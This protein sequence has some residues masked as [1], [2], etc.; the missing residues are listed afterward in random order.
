[1]RRGIRKATIA[2]TLQQ[3]WSQK[4]G[5]AAGADGAEQGYAFALHDAAADYLPSS[6]GDSDVK[7]RSQFN[8]DSASGAA[9]EQLQPSYVVFERGSKLSKTLET[10]RLYRLQ[11]AD[12]Q[13][14]YLL[15]R[16]DEEKFVDSVKGSATLS[17]DQKLADAAFDLQQGGTREPRSGS[18]NLASGGG[19]RPLEH[20]GEEPDSTAT[21][22]G[23]RSVR[24]QARLLEVVLVPQTSEMEY[25][26]ENLE[27]TLTARKQMTKRDLWHY[28]RELLDLAGKSQAPVFYQG[29]VPPASEYLVEGAVAT[30]VSLAAVGSS[31]EQA[32]PSTGSTPA[33]G[34]GGP[35]T[36]SRGVANIS[37]AAA[38]P[39]N[40]PKV[41]TSGGKTGG[42]TP[43][44]SSATDSGKRAPKLQSGLVVKKTGI[45]FRSTAAEIFMFIEISQEIFDFSQAGEAL[46]YQMLRFMS[47]CIELQKK[48]SCDH[49]LVILLFGRSRH[50]IGC[51]KPG[52]HG[53]MTPSRGGPGQDAS[54]T[55]V[56]LSTPVIAA[57]EDSTSS[58]APLHPIKTCKNY[59]SRA[60]QRDDQHSIL[61]SPSEQS[62]ALTA[63]NVSHL[64]SVK[65]NKSTTTVGFEMT[66]EEQ[67]KERTA[68]TSS[69][70]R[71]SMNAD[72]PRRTETLV[73]QKSFP[74]VAASQTVQAQQEDSKDSTPRGLGAARQGEDS[75]E[76]GT[77]KVPLAGA[78]GVFS[79][80]ERGAEKRGTI[81]HGNLLMGNGNARAKHGVVGTDNLISSP[82]SGSA[83]FD[84]QQPA[85]TPKVGSGTITAPE[86]EAVTDWFEV[87]W[88]GALSSLP[89]TSEFVQALSERISSFD[90]RTQSNRF[91]GDVDQV[92]VAPVTSTRVS[93]R[94]SVELGGSCASPRPRQAYQFHN[95]DA[96][97]SKHRGSPFVLGRS[98]VGGP[99]VA[100]GAT[101]TTGA[102]MSASSDVIGTKLE[103]G[104]ED[105]QRSETI[106][107]E[108]PIG[109]SPEVMNRVDT[110]GTS[111]S[112]S[113]TALDVPALRK[114]GIVNLVPAST[115]SEVHAPVLNKPPPPSSGMSGPTFSLDGYKGNRASGVDSGAESVFSGHHIAAGCTP[116]RGNSMRGQIVQQDPST[117]NVISSSQVDAATMAIKTGG[118]HNKQSSMLPNLDHQHSAERL[119]ISSSVLSQRMMSASCSDSFDASGGRCAED[120][121]A[122]ARVDTISDVQEPSLPGSCRQLPFLEALNVALDAFEHH[123]LDRNL[124]INGQAI[125][126]LSANHGVVYTHK[127]LFLLTQRRFSRMGVRCFLV[128]FRDRPLHRVPLVLVPRPGGLLHS[129]HAVKRDAFL[130]GAKRTSSSTSCAGIGKR[131]GR[132]NYKT[133]QTQEHHSEHQHP[134]FY[135]SSSNMAVTLQEEQYLHTSNMLNELGGGV[136]WRNAKNSA[137]A[138]IQ[139]GNETYSSASG[140]VTD[141]TSTMRGNMGSGTN[142]EVPQHQTGVSASIGGAGVQFVFLDEQGSDSK[143]DARHNEEGQQGRPTSQEERTTAAGPPAAGG[144]KKQGAEATTA[145]TGVSSTSTGTTAAPVARGTVQPPP[146]QEQKHLLDAVASPSTSSPRG[147]SLHRVLEEGPFSGSNTDSRA[148]SR[149]IREQEA[150]L[151][152]PWHVDGSPADSTP[153]SSCESVNA[154]NPTMTQ[155]SLGEPSLVSSG[156]ELLLDHET[157]PAPSQQLQTEVDLWGVAYGKTSSLDF[158]RQKLKAQQAHSKVVR[159][160]GKPAAEVREFFPGNHTSSRRDQ[161]AGVA[162]GGREH[163]QQDNLIVG[164]ARGSRER[165][166][167]SSA[168]RPFKYSAG[169]GVLGGGQLSGASPVW[170]H[171]YS[172]QS[173][174]GSQ[175]GGAPFLLS[176]GPRVDQEQ[177]V[178]QNALTPEASHPDLQHF[179]AASSS[180]ALLAGTGGSHQFLHRVDSSGQPLSHRMSYNKYPGSPDQHNFLMKSASRM[181]SSSLIGN[182]GSVSQLRMLGSMLAA[183]PSGSVPSLIPSPASKILMRQVSQSGYHNM[184]LQ[185]QAASR[186]EPLNMSGLA[187]GRAL[188]GC[189]RDIRASNI[190]VRGDYNHFCKMGAIGSASFQNL[191]SEAVMQHHSFDHAAAQRPPL[192]QAGHSNTDGVRT[193]SAQQSLL[194][195]TLNG[196][197]PGVHASS[198][199]LSASSTMQRRRHGGHAVPVVNYTQLQHSRGRKVTTRRDGILYLPLIANKVEGRYNRISSSTWVEPS[200]GSNTRKPFQKSRGGLLLHSSY[201]HITFWGNEQLNIQRLHFYDNA[202]RICVQKRTAGISARRALKM[203][204]LSAAASGA[205]TYVPTGEQYQPRAGGWQR[206]PLK[207]LFPEDGGS[208]GSDDG[209]TTPS[210]GGASCKSSKD[211]KTKTGNTAA[212]GV[213]VVVQASSQ[214][215]PLQLSRQRNIGPVPVAASS[216]LEARGS[217]TG[218]EEVRREGTSPARTINLAAPVSSSSSFPCVSVSS[219]DRTSMMSV[220]REKQVLPAPGAS[221]TSANGGGELHSHSHGQFYNIYGADQQNPDCTA[222]IT[223]QQQERV[224][225][226]GPSGSPTSLS[227]EATLAASTIKKQMRSG[228]SYGAGH[229]HLQQGSFATLA[230]DDFHLQVQQEHLVPHGG[231]VSPGGDVSTSP[232]FT[233]VASEPGF[234]RLRYQEMFDE[235]APNF[236]AVVYYPEVSFFDDSALR[237]NISSLYGLDSLLEQC[238]QFELSRQ[239]RIE[240]AAAEAV[241]RQVDFDRT[242]MKTT[243]P[244]EGA[245]DVGTS[246]AENDETEISQSP[247]TSTITKRSDGKRPQQRDEG[248]EEKLALFQVVGIDDAGNDTSALDSDPGEQSKTV[249]P[250]LRTEGHTNTMEE[251]K[252][253]LLPEGLLSNHDTERISADRGASRLRTSD[254][255]DTDRMLPDAGGRQNNKAWMKHLQ[256]CSAAAGLAN[257][258]GSAALLLP[259]PAEAFFASYRCQSYLQERQNLGRFPRD[260]LPGSS[261]K[262]GVYDM[263]ASGTRVRAVVELEAVR[264]PP[265]RQELVKYYN[266]V[267]QPRGRIE[268]RRSRRRLR[269]RR[270]RIKAG[271]GHAK[272]LCVGGDISE[273]QGLGDDAKERNSSSTSTSGTTSG[274]SEVSEEDCSTGSSG[275]DPQLQHLGAKGQ[276]HQQDQCSAGST[277]TST[278]P[279]FVRV[280]GRLRRP[281][282]VP[283]WTAQL[284]DHVAAGRH[285]HAEEHSEDS[286]T[287]VFSTPRPPAVVQTSPRPLLGDVTP[288]TIG[289]SS[290]SKTSTGRLMRLG[291]TP[292]SSASSRLGGSGQ[293]FFVSPARNNMVTWPRMVRAKEPLRLETMFEVATP[294]HGGSDSEA[295]LT[296][297]TTAP[298]GTNQDEN[299]S[300][301]TSI[302]SQSAEGRSSRPLGKAG[303]GIASSAPPINP[304]DVLPATGRELLEQAA[305]R[306][307][308]VASASSSGVEVK[309]S[310]STVNNKPTGLRRV[311]TSH[312]SSP[313]MGLPVSSSNPRVLKA[314]TLEPTSARRVQLAG[315]VGSA[316]DYQQQPLPNQAGQ[317]TA[318]QKRRS[319]SRPNPFSRRH[320]RP[321][322]IGREYNQQGASFASHADVSRGRRVLAPV[323]ESPMRSDE[324]G[325]GDE[326]TPIHMISAGAGSTTTRS[327]TT[328]SNSRDLA[329]QR[330]GGEAAESSTPSLSPEKRMAHER[331]TSRH[332]RPSGKKLM[333]QKAKRLLGKSLLEGKH[334]QSSNALLILSQRRRLNGAAFSNYG[335]S[336][337]GYKN[338]RT[339]QSS[340]LG[341]A[342]NSLA[343][344]DEDRAG[345]LVVGPGGATIEDLDV[346][347]REE[348]ERWVAARFELSEENPSYFKKAQLLGLTALW[349]VL[350]SP[351]LLP[352]FVERQRSDMGRKSD[353]WSCISTREGSANQ[354][355]RDL[356]GTRLVCGMQVFREKSDREISISASADMRAAVVGGGSKVDVSGVRAVVC[357]FDNNW[358]LCHSIAD[359]ITVT[360]HDK[361]FAAGGAAAAAGGGGAGGSS[362]SGTD[363]N[364]TTLQQSSLLAGGAS[365]SP[366]MMRPQLHHGVGSTRLGPAP[367]PAGTQRSLSQQ[368]LGSTATVNLASMT[369]TGM[370]QEVDTVATSNTAM[371]SSG[372]GDSAFLSGPRDATG[373][374]SSFVVGGSE[375]SP[376]MLVASGS[377]QASAAQYGGSGP[378]SARSSSRLRATSPPMENLSR[379]VVPR[380]QARTMGIAGQQVRQGGNT[381]GGV[382]DYRSSPLLA[383]ATNSS[384]SVGPKN[385]GDTLSPTL[386]GVVPLPRGPQSVARASSGPSIPGCSRDYSM[387]KRAILHENGALV[388]GTSPPAG[389]HHHHGISTEEH[390]LSLSMGDGNGSTPLAGAPGAR[391]GIS[392][393]PAS[394]MGRYQAAQRGIANKRPLQFLPTSSPSNGASR[395]VDVGAML[396]KNDTSS[397]AAP[398]ASRSKSSRENLVQQTRLAEFGNRRQRDQDGSTV[399]EE[400]KIALAVA[401][402]A[403]VNDTRPRKNISLPV[404]P[405]GSRALGSSE[406]ETTKRQATEC[407][408]AT[409]LATLPTSRQS[410]LVDLPAAGAQ[411]TSPPNLQGGRSEGEGFIGGSSAGQPSAQ[412]VFKQDEQVCLV[413]GNALEFRKP[414]ETSPAGSLDAVSASSPS[415]GTISP[416]SITGTSAGKRSLQSDVVRAQRAFFSEGAFP[417]APALRVPATS[418][419]T[420]ATAFASTSGI[421]PKMLNTRGKR[422]AIAP[423]QELFIS[424]QHVEVD[425]SARGGSRHPRAEGSALPDD[426]E[427]RAAAQSRPL[428][429]IELVE[430]TPGA[431]QA[432]QAFASPS[433]MLLE[434]NEGPIGNIDQFILS[435]PPGGGVGTVRGSVLLPGEGSLHPKGG[436]GAGNLNAQTSRAAI[437]DIVWPY[438]YILRR[439]ILRFAKRA[440][441]FAE[442]EQAAL[443]QPVR[444]PRQAVAPSSQL[445]AGPDEGMDAANK[446]RN[447]YTNNRRSNFS[448]SELEQDLQ[449]DH[450]GAAGSSSTV[451]GRAGGDGD[452]RGG[453]QGA[454]EDDEDVGGPMDALTASPGFQRLLSSSAKASD[455]FSAA[456]MSCSSFSSSSN[457]TGE[458]DDHVSSGGDGAGAG[459]NQGEP[460][461]SAAASGACSTAFALPVWSPECRG[462]AK[463]FPQLQQSGRQNALV[464]RTASVQVGGGMQR[465]VGSVGLQVVGGEEMFD[466][467]AFCSPT[468]AARRK[469]NQSGAVGVM[470]NYQR[471]LKRG[472][473]SPTSHAI[474]IGGVISSNVVES[475]GPY[476]PLSSIAEEYEQYKVRCARSCAN[477]S[478]NGWVLQKRLFCQAD[479]LP[480]NVIDQIVSE[481]HPLPAATPYPL[482]DPNEKTPSAYHTAWWRLRNVLRSIVFVLLPVDERRVEQRQV[483]ENLRIGEDPFL[484]DCDGNVSAPS[485]GGGG[486]GGGGENGSNSKSGARASPVVGADSNVKTRAP[487]KKAQLGSSSA[488]ENKPV[489]FSPPS[490]NKQHKGQIEDTR[491]VIGS[492]SDPWA[493]SRDPSNVFLSEG[494]EP[495]PN[496]PIAGDADETPHMVL[497]NQQ[498]DAVDH[499]LGGTSSA[500]VDPSNKR[501]MKT[502]LLPGVQP[503][504]PSTWSSAGA[505]SSLVATGF[506][507]VGVAPSSLS[508]KDPSDGS[509]GKLEDHKSSTSDEVVEKGATGTVSPIVVPRKLSSPA[510]RPLAPDLRPL[511]DYKPRQDHTTSINDAPHDQHQTGTMGQTRKGP[512]RSRRERYVEHFRKLK[513]GLEAYLFY[514]A[515][516]GEGEQGAD[517]NRKKNVL[518][519]EIRTGAVS[520]ASCGSS[521]FQREDNFRRAPPTR[522]TAKVPVRWIEKRP[523]PWSS[524]EWLQLHHDNFY[525]PLDVFHISVEWILCSNAT[526]WKFVQ[527]LALLAVQN[528][529]RLQPIPHGE[530]LPQLSQR[531][532]MNSNDTELIYKRSPFSSRIGIR[533]PIG[534]RFNHLV[535]ALL[536]P[537]LNLV[538]VYH[539]EERTSKIIYNSSTTSTRAA[540]G[541]PAGLG[542]VGGGDGGEKDRSIEQ[543]ILSTEDEQT[544]MLEGNTKT[545]ST[546]HHQ[547]NYRSG[548]AA[549]A[550][551]AASSQLG[552][553]RVNDMLSRLIGL[554]YSNPDMPGWI[555]MQRESG[556]YFITVTRTQIFWTESKF[557]GR[558]ATKKLSDGMMSSYESRMDQHFD[559]FK[560]ALH[561]IWCESRQVIMRGWDEDEHF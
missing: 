232:E 380:G 459:Q 265:K 243:T 487:G 20:L 123:T 462:S 398:S 72:S 516:D 496:L 353:N 121:F 358:E 519:I 326:M 60:E 515:P 349:S 155:H 24:A 542:E 225:R 454:F 83:T 163:Q 109:Y 209:A 354:L 350:K 311:L 177:W 96:R 503:A 287:S 313:G 441:A 357:N 104:G 164:S 281:L 307:S 88:S 371:P 547:N 442:S 446:S 308:W 251:S 52:A 551:G 460:T 451:T 61:S 317:T 489:L 541:A 200:A 92:E 32:P 377:P 127:Q 296:N 271:N 343:D 142:P 105:L 256:S 493:S 540:G 226:E 167:S 191:L 273:E 54:G 491:Y 30:S 529:F 347:A 246:D 510:P 348:S 444:G 56:V 27:V 23:L 212:P 229:L 456:S 252:Q 51:K 156:G 205:S 391:I 319:R 190:V 511:P 166:Q 411:Q 9:G 128:C 502:T 125:F 16:I 365:W 386:T 345:Q 41:V 440:S 50:P 429:P 559:D 427:P 315:A 14:N 333:G 25:E 303:I 69:V 535:E 499:Q 12:A 66:L 227:H 38:P 524:N 75:A 363:D 546:L 395:S 467:A 236:F 270:S 165:F 372:N 37:S 172:N 257:N 162:R 280:A 537:P 294:K 261:K 420:S 316:A 379:Q 199:K 495:G 374:A 259:S 17:I 378:S 447:N 130:S 111:S 387:S 509:S 338:P 417:F 438:Q 116:T 332:G 106:P 119:S 107:P 439:N 304:A 143:E 305:G 211:T 385:A 174:W 250:N 255:A 431:H 405:E 300:P 8:K 45:S 346:E 148:A 291:A 182:C 318:E 4:R 362:P 397:S 285:L 134:D 1:M 247:S 538:L 418:S 55:P 449:Q 73:S 129:Y 498:E 132:G 171:F 117:T 469:T 29:F 175:Q 483:R 352:I 421:E 112:E 99:S 309:T 552:G 76:P 176:R 494:V 53:L 328:K 245:G 126:V 366:S 274:S 269:L 13:Y 283:R 233:V 544:N 561:R 49:E 355:F 110:T 40:M 539:H 327:A 120:L 367:A 450:G 426:G 289:V 284:E 180:P 376:I 74:P 457:S 218:A 331:S 217:R 7:E 416:T 324:G 401:A 344:E 443:A 445:A 159:P 530:L 102:V 485:G 370:I 330:G 479:P 64:Q 157:A 373:Q 48:A 536:S 406:D 531:A 473:I 21:T 458:Q 555:F 67:H 189:D 361:V 87:A 351:P 213:F 187:S 219:P 452:D 290:T 389:E 323:S 415:E 402:P 288:L 223:S 543:E 160:G 10:G 39:T 556:L 115:T 368:A 522:R 312:V 77:W 455:P 131:G 321:N 403:A 419:S 240:K 113:T 424:G 302:T 179:Y 204:I 501:N 260:L 19:S 153:T 359:Q 18:G 241:R 173:S 396:S 392:R 432:Q 478:R 310:V 461:R 222:A 497:N 423:D 528:R 5:G 258:F 122:E 95:T 47:E 340:P 82:A 471:D 356:V 369:A 97:L 35:T 393:S 231:V 235:L 468:A 147:S 272:N 334:P 42:L 518:D 292:A 384:P 466:A 161:A 135:G 6:V 476:S 203:N 78:R 249:I 275:S 436:G 306:A 103:S 193:G 228:T 407:S 59:N 533:I 558:K 500:A 215:S 57:H 144:K 242:Q 238:T 197:T 58:S 470:F 84:E 505:P 80:R 512:K 139:T 492:D 138:I 101:T 181:S 394:M 335:S 170:Q 282:F 188:L 254:V 253:L 3:R 548:G 388:D 560:R 325:G 145:T 342:G 298:G 425:A 463:L 158:A 216:S 486:L 62:R 448:T 11:F 93:K 268:R 428:S 202:L 336:S 114:S 472:V 220:P 433:T 208:G 408:C 435:G 520:S 207:G 65:V 100:P 267:Q 390:P 534:V 488:K 532:V 413:R 480:W 44:S 137:P 553:D 151:S 322:I 517:K 404:T 465:T 545:W 360:Q 329:R 279:A 481:A 63:E 554:D 28:Q 183:N 140:T 475:P 169:G 146:G 383:H 46:Y 341:R 68:S 453:L 320:S 133:S 79:G 178:I 31:Q 278:S 2:D 136:S 337:G 71:D 525:D 297:T 299:M 214:S 15:V 26:L 210:G 364:A 150:Y 521:S 43:S 293:P 399:D 477:F 375:R 186:G 98:L 514:N 414:L 36:G 266:N 118:H 490:R 237:Q 124:L 276:P 221:L 263:A 430:G 464:G 168:H 339:L 192:E 506:G 108:L 400:G 201:S 557:L 484:V 230:G 409:S 94:G 508:P 504:G 549:R 89:S 90:P 152:P 198:G 410:S 70:G 194:S 264:N 239:R 381:T 550:G 482:P 286:S 33:A 141:V 422:S 149:Q 434:Q 185:Q 437:D 154:T 184:L 513:A 301:S 382:V 262:M 244:N 206:T 224:E 196:T 81:P 277:S 314:G 86:L 526:A 91:R 412:L 527:T 85:T 474:G 248:A 22:S 507:R 234:R 523:S 195:S 295:A 34:D